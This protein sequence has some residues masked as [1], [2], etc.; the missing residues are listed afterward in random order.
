MLII[1][2]KLSDKNNIKFKNLTTSA[3]LAD[4]GSIGNTEY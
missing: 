4:A 1:S 2:D 3:I